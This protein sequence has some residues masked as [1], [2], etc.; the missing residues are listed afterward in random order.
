M[1][2]SR[3]R[4]GI[5]SG[6]P[7]EA[8]RSAKVASISCGSY[9]TSACLVAAA[10]ISSFSIPSYTGL[11]VYFGPPKT[12]A[13]VSSARR[14]ANSATAWQMLRSMRSVRKAASCSPSPSRHSLAP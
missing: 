4:A 6:S 13:P 11:T 7:L 2:P 9:C 5:T 10:S 1:S 14:N 8:T 12:L 3:L